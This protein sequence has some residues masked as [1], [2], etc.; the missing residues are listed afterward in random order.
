[1]QVI[2]KKFTF[3]ASH[4]LWRD[5][6][7]VNK[8]REVFGKCSRLHGHNYYVEIEVTGE[9]DIVDGMIMNYYAIG[10]VI[11]KL[12]HRHLNEMMELLPTAENLSVYIA[13]QVENEAHGRAQV[14][15]VMVKETDS[16]FAVYHP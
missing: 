3:A 15:R 2:G 10:N 4:Q 12:D 13:Q 1:M 7:D 8:N 5:D 16:S 11:T 14:L 6:W 9:V